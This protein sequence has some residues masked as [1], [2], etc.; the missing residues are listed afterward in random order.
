MNYKIIDSH[1]HPQLKQFDLDRDEVITRA[2]EHG[3]GM[4]C[5]GTNLDTSR[6]GNLLSERYEG[7]Y[8]SVGSHPIDEKSSNFDIQEYERL[9]QHPKVVAIG[10][11]G[12]DYFHAKDSD[13][14][15]EQ[16]I[17]FLAQVELAKKLQ[18]PIII[19]CRDPLRPSVNEAC[20]PSIGVASAHADMLQ[21]LPNIS[22]VIHSFN[23]STERAHRYIQKGFFIGLNAIVTYAKSY[24]EMVCSLPLDRILLETDAPYLAPVPYRGKRNEPAYVIHV[25]EALAL[26]RGETLAVV[27]AQTVENTRRLFSMKE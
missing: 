3:V 1:C 5:V 23:G 20:P 19:H 9:A 4:V 25:A 16:K 2:L 7:L 11:I 22:G 8:T 18:K 10:E 21:I 6:Q 26:V 27:M 15:A 17:R 12:L 14:H 24:E 13:E